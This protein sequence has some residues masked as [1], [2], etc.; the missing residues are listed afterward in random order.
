MKRASSLNRIIATFLAATAG[1]NLMAQ[2]I[3]VVRAFAGAANSRVSGRVDNATV[4]ATAVTTG[5]TLQVAASIPNAGDY[6]F[7]AECRLREGIDRKPPLVAMVEERRPDSAHSH[8][9][10]TRVCSTT[11]AFHGRPTFRAGPPWSRKRTRSVRRRSTD[12]ID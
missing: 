12:G 11:T 4:T 3:A 6:R 8:I 10:W 2:L 7:A 5:T 1:G 9:V